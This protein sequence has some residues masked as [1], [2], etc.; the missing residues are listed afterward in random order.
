[1]NTETTSASRA[2]SVSTNSGSPRLTSTRAISLLLLGRHRRA[3]DRA[4]LHLLTVRRPVNV[5]GPAFDILHILHYVCTLLTVTHSTGFVPLRATWL[6]V[7]AS[8]SP[9]RHH[10]N[11]EDQ[12][13]CNAS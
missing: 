8:R 6:Y 3:T 11:A 12:P 4:A 1:N 7:A 5:T 10:A 13:H 9:A 2:L